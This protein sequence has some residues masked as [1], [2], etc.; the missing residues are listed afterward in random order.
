MAGFKDYLASDLVT[1]FNPD[2]FSEFHDIDGLQVQALVDRDVM[3][4]RSTQRYD[5]VYKGEVA[6]FVRAADLPS[7][8]V[9]GQHMRLDGKLYLVAEC[10]ENCGMLEIILEA[11]ES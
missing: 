8:P 1:F 6:V 10:G 7:C 5:G 11:N 3:K 4:V 9:Y 2:E